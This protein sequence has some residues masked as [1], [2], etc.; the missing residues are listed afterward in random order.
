MNPAPRKICLVTPTLLTVHAFLKPHLRALSERFDVTL[1]YNPQN[2]AYTPPLDLP[3]QETHVRIER[4]IRL[5]ADL[6]ALIHLYLLFRREQF[7]LVISVAPKAGLLGMLAGK[8]AGIP[9]RVHIFQGEVWAS[10]TGFMRR[11]LKTT[12]WLTA[13]A[14]SHLLAVGHGEKT[15]LEEQGISPSGRITV[16]GPGSISGVDT[17]KFK[18]D[19]NTRTSMRKAH[20]IPKDACVCLFLGRFYAEKGIFEL[21]EAFK[22]A[23]ENNANLWLFLV[24]PDEADLA[25]RLLASVEP[26]LRNR[27]VIEGFTNAPELY[28]SAADVFC[29]PSYREGFA[30]SVLEASASGL[31]TIGSRIYGIEGGI[32]DNETGLLVPPRDA[33]ALANAISTL[34]RDK[35]LRQRMGAAGQKRMKDVFEQKKVV[36]QYINFFCSLF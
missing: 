35:P 26:N 33:I 20:N 7:D 22:K 8:A 16:L 14:A 6:A 10:R 3:V 24:G 25:E 34:S 32:L 9:R 19:P 18:T 2:D 27:I 21:I 4:K 5:G 1:A 17:V 15:F 23:A 29:L 36:G 13:R 30:V 12:D 28:F 31:P 11:L